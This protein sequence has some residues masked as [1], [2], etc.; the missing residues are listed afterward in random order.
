M[1]RQELQTGARAVR[2]VMDKVNAMNLT[3]AKALDVSP[4]EAGRLIRELGQGF[5]AAISILQSMRHDLRSSATTCA[6]CT[7]IARA[8]GVLDYDDFERILG[9]LE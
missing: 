3:G 8:L 9:D 5:V 6:T 2:V 7:K 1:S 4:A